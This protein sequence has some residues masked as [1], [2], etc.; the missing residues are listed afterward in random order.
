MNRRLGIFVTIALLVAPAAR[1]ADADQPALLL[2]R[3]SVARHQ[4]VAIGRDARIEGDAEAGVTALNGSV[5]IEGTVEGDVSVLGGDVEVGPGAVVR[6]DVFVLGGELHA[7]PG[8]RLEGRSV[9]YP[10]LSRASL[11]LLE[12]P[13]LGL[14]A[15]APLVLAAKLALVAAWLG[16]T[17]LLFA[18]GGRAVAATSEEIVAEP[19]RCFAAGLVG[20]LALV[21]TALFLSSLLPAVVSVPTL[22]LAVIAAL[23]A[24]LWG[25]VGVFHALGGMLARLAGRRLRR[26]PAPLHAAV[27]GLAFLAVLK[28]IPWLGIWAWTAASLV[29]VGAALRTKFG[30]REPWFAD[31]LPLAS[32]GRP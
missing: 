13:S 19:L 11:T 24:K 31:D 5:R 6:G 15:S 28:L 8:A 29:G 25:M 4:I 1:A 22:V 18:S 23:L 17:L 26:A 21:V 10:T 3:G 32:P 30:R 14:S 12:G 9:A 16:L 2:E 20:V 27:L 7:D